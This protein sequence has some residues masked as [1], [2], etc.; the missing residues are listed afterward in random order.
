MTTELE[1]QF[2]DTFGIE[3][4]E[5]KS[6]D[7]GTFCPYDNQLCDDTCPYYRT[8]KVDYPEITDNILLELIC[9]INKRSDFGLFSSKIDELKDEILDHCLILIGDDTD[10]T[11]GF[12]EEIKQQVQALFKE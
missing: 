9:I 7:V 11:T 1:K 4:K 2:F 12:E 6:C 5:F 10:Y 8:Y 3:P